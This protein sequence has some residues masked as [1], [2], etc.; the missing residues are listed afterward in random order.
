MT[1]LPWGSL[2]LWEGLAKAVILAERKQKD[3]CL[4]SASYV[5]YYGHTRD[6]W[7]FLGWGLNPRCSCGNAGSFKPS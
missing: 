1:P 3:P 4:P 6:L 2:R 7:K 5:F